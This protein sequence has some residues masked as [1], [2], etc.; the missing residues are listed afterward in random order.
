LIEVLLS[1][2]FI[3]L[4]NVGKASRMTVAKTVFAVWRGPSIFGTSTPRL[5]QSMPNYR[6]QRFSG[7]AVFTI[8]GEIFL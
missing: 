3:L 5:L 1:M 7:Q 6:R 8:Q 4:P 2:C